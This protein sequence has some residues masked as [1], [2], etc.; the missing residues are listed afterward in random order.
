MNRPFLSV[1]IAGSPV[2]AI[3]LTLGGGWLILTWARG[4]A[5]F[6]FALI[7]LFVIAKTLS[8][9]GK[10]RRYKAWAKE[11]D[12]VGTFGQ[13]QPVR[14]KV[15]LSLLLTL[16]A[17]ALFIGILVCWPQAA[18]RPQLQ[19]VLIWTWLSCG[20]FLVGRL[21]VGIASLVAKRRA[22]KPARA[23]DEVAPVAWML[24][25]TLDSP[26]REMA[27]RSLPEYA[28]RVLTPQPVMATVATGRGVHAQG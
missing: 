24:N 13:R 4:G 11:W 6:W 10:V 20:L 26:S 12:S 5:S 17:S 19:N 1:R 9:A 7:G 25:A 28:A 3:P 18:D 15:R 14:R 8:A 21:V 16:I 27:T 22:V 23:K 2:A